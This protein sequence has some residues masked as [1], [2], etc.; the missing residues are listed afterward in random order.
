MVILA[1]RL[2]VHPYISNFCIILFVYNGFCFVEL[3][4]FS[5]L[6]IINSVLDTVSFSLSV[7]SRWHCMRLKTFTRIIWSENRY[8]TTM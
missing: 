8:I 5:P 2:Q 4:R 6:F 7:L 1:R 3:E